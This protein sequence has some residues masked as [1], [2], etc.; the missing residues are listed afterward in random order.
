MKKG[1]TLLELI[2]VII[3]IGVLG[4]LGFTQYTRVTEKGRTSEAKMILGNVRT[5]QEGFKQE[6]GSYTGTIG[7]LNVDVPT[8]C[9]ATHYFTYSTSATVGTATRCTV[10]GKTPNFVGTAYTITMTYATGAWGGSTGYY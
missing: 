5:S 4:T 6:Y 2:V 9:T 1:F 10:N 7:D 8:S 3:I